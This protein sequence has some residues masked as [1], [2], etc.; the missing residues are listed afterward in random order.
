MGLQT[1]K[2][3]YDNHPQSLETHDTRVE[4]ETN[5][6]L[7]GRKKGKLT[8]RRSERNQLTTRGSEK[9][10]AHD[11]RDG[12]GSTHDARVG[13]ESNSRREGRKR[14]KLTTRGSEKDQLTTR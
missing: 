8:T 4:N 9:D 2:G 11:A 5:S 3:V 13:K 7:E 6:R 10:H 14:I 12:K 1:H